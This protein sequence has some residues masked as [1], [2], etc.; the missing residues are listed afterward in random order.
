[1]GYGAGA[2]DFYCRFENGFLSRLDEIIKA[3]KLAKND[4]NISG[5]YLMN[6]AP[7]MGYASLESLRNTLLDF[8][9]SGKF[10]YGYSEIYTEKGY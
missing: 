9:K 5:I 3:I 6:G 4:K 1:M 10:I 7:M 2:K 8:K